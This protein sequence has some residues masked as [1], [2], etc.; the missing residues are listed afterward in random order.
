MV[1]AV[2]DAMTS[3]VP[4]PTAV[5]PQLPLYHFNDP[6]APPAA[7]RLM[8]PASSAQ[9]LLRSTD[10][11]VGAV[12]LAQTVIEFVNVKTLL[13]VPVHVELENAVNETL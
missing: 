6:P 13:A 5:P 7:E 10:A 8:L 4:V 12:A 9:K 2:G 11:D 3:G 1:V